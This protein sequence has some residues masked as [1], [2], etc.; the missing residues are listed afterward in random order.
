MREQATRVMWFTVRFWGLA[1]LLL[2]S[3]VIINVIRSGGVD[4]Y[5]KGT[6][7]AL[8]LYGLLCMFAGECFLFVVWF[9][10]SRLG[11]K[12]R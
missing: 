9:L 11:N 5:L 2:L 1:F 3:L 4:H 6:W 10:L 8:E 12:G 7:S